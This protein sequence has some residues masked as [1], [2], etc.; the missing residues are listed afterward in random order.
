MRRAGLGCISGL[1]F[2]GFLIG[3]R[4][5]GLG[6]PVRH[7]S[8]FIKLPRDRSEVQPPSAEEKPA[9]NLYAK[10]V[11]LYKRARLFDSQCFVARNI[12]RL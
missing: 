11:T 7:V 9:R 4:V 12:M 8:S 5:R 6:F 10:R 3:F 2:T 1:L